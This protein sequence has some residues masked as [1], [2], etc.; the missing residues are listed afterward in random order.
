[1][2]D[3]IGQHPPQPAAFSAEPV[4]NIGLPPLAQDIET[5]NPTAT[6]KSALHQLRPIVSESCFRQLRPK[7]PLRCD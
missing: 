3:E 1:M 6:P 2:R 5:N 7:N 4:G